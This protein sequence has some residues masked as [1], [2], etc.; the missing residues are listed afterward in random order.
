MSSKSFRRLFVAAAFSISSLSLV[1]TTFATD[2][3][4]AGQEKVADTWT[5]EKCRSE[6]IAFVDFAISEVRSDLEKKGAAE[7]E[8]SDRIAEISAKCRELAKLRVGAHEQACQFRA[9][10]DAAVYP[11]N[12]GELCYPG[13]ESVR[14]QVSLL[15]AEIAG[16]DRTC[17][18]L[19]RT[20]RS[21]VRD[22]EELVVEIND[23]DARLV[24]LTTKRARLGVVAVRGQSG[25][26]LKLVN[27]LIPEYCEKQTDHERRVVLF[28]DGTKAPCETPRATPVKRRKDKTADAKKKAANQKQ[29]REVAQRA[30]IFQQF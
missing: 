15:L 27:R 26:L 20:R 14:Q 18:D 29:S 19:K 30:P 12:Q 22:R 6:P 5:A 24:Q 17:M 23:L 16:Y 8:L 2:V 11:V 25:E 7:K 4:A 10:I 21:A 3:A 13:P 28:L 1:G 9:H